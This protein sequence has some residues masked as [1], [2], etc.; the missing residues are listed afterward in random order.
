MYRVR[1]S[2]DIDGAHL[3]V[4]PSLGRADEIAVIVIQ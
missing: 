4:R 3:V 2:K 1:A